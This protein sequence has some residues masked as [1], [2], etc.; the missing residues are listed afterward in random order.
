[1]FDGRLI[2]N[3]S[4]IFNWTN[5]WTNVLTICYVHRKEASPDGWAVCGVVESTRW[6]LLLTIY[7][8]TKFIER[9]SFPFLK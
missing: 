2:F 9:C 4:L 8:Q 5:E 3:E 7:K 1:M 6:W